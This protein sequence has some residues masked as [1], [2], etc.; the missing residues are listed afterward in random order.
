MSTFLKVAI[1]LLLT[2]PLGA[3]IAGTLVASQASM[4][5]ERR[6]VVIEATT[7]SD[8]PSATPSRSPS[9]SPESTPD[10]HSGEGGEHGH[11]GDDDGDD[12]SVTVVR[13]TPREVDDDREDRLEDRADEA[14]DRA[15]DAEDRADD[16]A[17]DD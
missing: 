14:E 10:D 9:R 13:P 17:D 12:D 15:D 3:Y 1:G 11:H 8:G 6:P 16:G 7:P 5:P 4:P 2:L